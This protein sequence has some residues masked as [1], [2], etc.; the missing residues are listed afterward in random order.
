MT[1]RFVYFAYGSNMLTRRLRERAPSA[2]A[3]GIGFVEGHRLTFDKVS[4]D[5]SGKCSI[6]STDDPGDRVYGVL[7]SIDTREAP[8]LDVA[9]GLGSGYQKADV[10]VVTPAGAQVAVAY[11]ADN[12]NSLLLPY[13]W[14]KGFVV[15]G[16]IEHSLPAV[17]VRRLQTTDSQV[18]PDPR[19]RA[20]NEAL[21]AEERNG[22]LSLRHP[23]AVG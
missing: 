18:D 4:A 5:G 10:R 9:E 13:D 15:R 19:R 8:D 14:Y 17:Y 6:E 23:H 11:I 12:T 21:L 3:V 20:K 16:A 7:F 1:D 22:T 2:T